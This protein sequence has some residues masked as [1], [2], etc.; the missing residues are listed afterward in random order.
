MDADFQWADEARLYFDI[1]VTYK[2]DRVEHRFPFVLAE[3]RRGE[4]MSLD[5]RMY[6][7][8]TTGMRAYELYRAIFSWHGNTKFADRA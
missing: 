8:M 1:A 6:R 3:D 7:R 2:P 4:G 5:E